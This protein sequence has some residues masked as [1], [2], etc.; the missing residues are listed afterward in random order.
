MKVLILVLILSL[1]LSLQ[2]CFKIETYSPEPKVTLIDFIFTDT[3]DELENEVRNGTLH[4]SF[5]D[6]DGDIGFDT[7]APQQKTIFLEKY[8]FIDGILTKLDFDELN[9]DYYI[10]KFSPTGNNK[11][12]Q[13]EIYVNDLNETK[14]FVGDTIMYTYYIVD[15]SGNKSNVDSTEFMIVY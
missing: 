8:K 2:S 3:V 10:P 6:G 15:R 11:A 7:T 1:F 13:G 14:P 12:L 4:F 9:L 5:V